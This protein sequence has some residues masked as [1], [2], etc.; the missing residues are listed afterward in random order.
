MRKQLR[1]A[2]VIASSLAVLV[3]SVILPVSAGASQEDTVP[4]V[5]EASDISTAQEWNMALENDSLPE[6]VVEGREVE[7]S[8]NVVAGV[9]FIDNDSD[10]MFDAIDF[11]LGEY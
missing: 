1:S 5:A 3:S 7:M 9:P 6:Q 11:Y 2:M 8:G 4:V 10:D